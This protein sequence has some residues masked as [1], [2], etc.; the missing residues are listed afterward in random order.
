MLKSKIFQWKLTRKKSLSILLS[1]V[2]FLSFS[3][4]VFGQDMQPDLN[5]L[6]QIAEELSNEST[7][8]DSQQAEQELKLKLELIISTM[9]SDITKMPEEVSEQLKN[10]INNTNP[11][12]MSL[13]QLL[14]LIKNLYNW[15]TQLSMTY[16][17]SVLEELS[18][19][20]NLSNQLSDCLNLANKALLS[21]KG[22]TENAIELFSAALEEVEIIKKEK[23]LLE[24]EWNEHQKLDYERDR[25][26]SNLYTLGN[27]LVP[28]APIGVAVCSIIPF[29][30]GD[31]RTGTTMLY[32]AG[33][34]LISLELIY[35]GGHFIFKFW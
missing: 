28:L 8:L 26:F 27:F 33:I 30:Q 6:N 22:D 24:F 29:S 18:S 13:P 2:L 32:S 25:R 15:Q 35:Q 20:K 7:L 31:I 12:S 3:H 5:E 17:T 34:S 4:S 19:M 16:S 21:N 1:L 10:L 23:E 11:N 14:K 9:Q